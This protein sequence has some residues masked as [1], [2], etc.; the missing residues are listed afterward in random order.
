MSSRAVALIVI[1]ALV[2][3]AVGAVLDWPILNVPWKAL[4]W[5]VETIVTF[6]VGTVAWTI[7]LIVAAFGGGVA[8]GTAAAASVP[9][10]LVSAAGV[11][12][13]VFVGTA[14]IVALRP[15]V[16]SAAKHPFKSIAPIVGVIAGFGT[17]SLAKAADIASPTAEF[18]AATNGLLVIA[19]GIL[20]KRPGSLAKF[21]SLLLFL[22][23]PVAIIADLLRRRSPSEVLSGAVS[24]DVSVW[25]GLGVVLVS[26]VVCGALAYETRDDD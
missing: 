26:A 4:E 20:I 10:I 19:G 23:V 18:L 15:V 14:S 25:I 21:V 13:F 5:V 3:S 24:M 1:V 8:A 9:V 12:G 11:V 6:V 2:L 17:A 7:A 16:A 22:L